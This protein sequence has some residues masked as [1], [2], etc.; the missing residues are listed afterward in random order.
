MDDAVDAIGEFM[1]DYSANLVELQEK[2]D[3]LE[4]R[5]I[6]NK[7]S[8]QLTTVDADNE[9][10]RKIE[11]A[12]TQYK[13][14]KAK[15]EEERIDL[16]K[17]MRDGQAW[18]TIKANF[19]MACKETVDRRT[20]EEEEREAFLNLLA[21]KYWQRLRNRRQQSLRMRRRLRTPT[22]WEIRKS[23][24]LILILIPTLSS[25]LRLTRKR[26][27]WLIPSL[28]PTPSGPGSL[29]TSGA[30]ALRFHCTK[31]TSQYCLTI[32]YHHGIR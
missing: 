26:K 6:N 19:K 8:L 3:S 15:V 25:T 32:N 2:L 1:E 10:K 31:K 30:R 21:R 22:S 29:V 11:V 4:R 14:V 20:E 23:S 18:E 28:F 12:R 7:T 16:L 5:E 17:R 24:I 13:K 27:T 9:W